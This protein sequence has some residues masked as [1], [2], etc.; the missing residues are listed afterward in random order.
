MKEKYSYAATKMV[1]Y[2][3]YPDIKKMDEEQ[4][5]ELF[6]NF[7]YLETVARNTFLCPYD[8]ELYQILN[9]NG[10][11]DSNVQYINKK[12]NID[13]EILKQK[14]QEYLKYNYIQCVGEN[15]I[16]YHI[17]FELSKEFLNNTSDSKKNIKIS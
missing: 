9:N 6:S 8:M 14:W 12:F 2:N 4:L 17:V 16:D 3:H 13:K 5:E 15:L 7:G 11:S 10:L 1:I